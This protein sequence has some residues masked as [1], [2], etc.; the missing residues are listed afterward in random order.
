MMQSIPVWIEA[1]PLMGR[2]YFGHL[3]LP[4]VE[5]HG[6]NSPVCPSSRLPSI[7]FRATLDTAFPHIHSWTPL[8]HEWYKYIQ[9][10][11]AVQ[12]APDCAGLKSPR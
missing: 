7:H 3:P 12:L 4:G 11:Q 1:S 10:L 8:G 2:L 6:A 9:N 5:M